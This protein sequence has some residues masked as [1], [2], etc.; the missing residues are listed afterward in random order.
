MLKNMK[1]PQFSILFGLFLAATLMSAGCGQK[2]EN[3]P[4]GTTADTDTITYMSDRQVM[5]AFDFDSLKGIF[6][7]KDGNLGFAVM[8]TDDGSWEQIAGSEPMIPAGGG[9]PV[10]YLYYEISPAGEK[11]AERDITGLISEH[12]GYELAGLTGDGQGNHYL[13]V[14]TLDRDEPSVLLAFD[15]EWRG[16]GRI[17]S[18]EPIQNL[19]CTADGE[20]Y[21][22][23]LNTHD[24]SH[25]ILRL[26]DW[27][28]Q[29]LKSGLEL[30]GGVLGD[31]ILAPGKEKDLLIHCASLLYECDTDTGACVPVMTWANHGINAE[32]LLWFCEDGNGNYQ[33]LLRTEAADTVHT[34]LVRLNQTT[35]DMVP[36]KEIIT[37]GLVGTSESI[38][39]DVISFNLSN[40]EYEVQI[41]D[42]STGDLM[43]SLT[44]MNLQLSGPEPP[45]IICTVTDMSRYIGAGVLADLY[46]YME[47]DTA[48]NSDDY[49]DNIL[50]EYEQDGK[51]YGVINKFCIKML[52]GNVDVLP[53]T[54]KWTTAEMLDFAAKH[55][56]QQLFQQQSSSDI[57]I[58]LAA[59]KIDEFVN[60]DT[61]ECYFESEEFISILEYAAKCG[62]ENPATL[63]DDAYEAINAGKFLLIDYYFNNA[64]ALQYTDTLFNGSAQYIGHPVSSYSESGI[65]IYDALVFGIHSNSDNKDGAWA[66][67]SYM[68]SD[69]CQNRIA[70]EDEA[71]PIKRSSV[72]RHIEAAMKNEIS[73]DENGNE[74]VKPKSYFTHY[75]LTGEIYAISEEQADQVRY[76]LENARGRYNITSFQTSMFG[77]IMEEAQ[78]YFAG[79]KTAV[80][81]ASII[82]NRIEIYVNESR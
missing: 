30:T 60:W 50:T 31:M 6:R 10:R 74:V 36:I 32:G 40:P 42:Y 64:L 12:G 55:Q 70:D 54:E 16:T 65:L 80:E 53:D 11:V 58:I 2:K 63:G 13:A 39:K 22:V 7:N 27:I 5:I 61:G 68:L 82:Q 1:C 73:I 72:E 25:F 48:F 15:P 62:Q 78:S 52:V 19:G 28:N 34:E 37:I 41:V 77:I 33:L 76:L 47:K 51:L 20:L 3:V 29:K 71:F 24:L 21:V 38:Q 44:Q 66:F 26:A 69:T 4:A 35:E 75:G 56:D 59:P 18:R 9:Q 8:A 17:A 46:P 67:L 57:M 23:T 14:R 45:D 43:S 79:Q 81:V 49:L